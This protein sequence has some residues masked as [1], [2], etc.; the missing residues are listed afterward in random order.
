MKQDMN[1]GIR[2]AHLCGN[3]F[4]AEQYSNRDFSREVYVI[5]P[6]III[7]LYNNIYN[8]ILHTFL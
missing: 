7:F 3:N 5:L 1:D 6:F 2:V 4:D 8:D